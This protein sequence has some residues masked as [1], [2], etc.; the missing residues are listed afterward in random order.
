MRESFG[1]TDEELIDFYLCYPDLH[2]IRKTESYNKEDLLTIELIQKWLQFDKFQSF[3][4]DFSQMNP[5]EQDFT[6]K[7][8]KEPAESPDNSS[9]LHLE[10]QN[11]TDIDVSLENFMK[12]MGM[13]IDG[14][15][16]AG[17]D[18]SENWT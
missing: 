15:F 3:M 14:K 8:V 18:A 17:L 6:Y 9:N 12:L 2:F 11:V 16:G 7:L 1:I 4:V 13:G 5:D 10:Q